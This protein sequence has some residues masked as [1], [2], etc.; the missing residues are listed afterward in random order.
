M[1]QSLRLKYHVKNI[2]IEQ[3]LSNNALFEHKC[4]QNTNKLYKHA[5]RGTS[6]DVYFD[7][8]LWYITKHS[9]TF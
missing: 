1:L 9:S 5:G 7:L 3:S 6:Q 8:I 4:L 2:G